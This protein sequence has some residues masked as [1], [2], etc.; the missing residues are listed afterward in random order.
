MGFL[1]RERAALE[2]LLPGLDAELA[3]LPLGALEAQGNPGVKLFREAGGAG[4]L[5]PAEHGGKGADALSAVRVQRAIGSRSPS[6]AV[7]TTMHHFSLA[8]LVVLSRTGN[9]FE[10]MLLTGIVDGRLLLA[11]GFA[12]GQPGG[13][14]LRPSMTAEV[15]EQGL[16]VSGAKRPCSLAR[17]MDLLTASV[18]VPRTDGTGEQLAVV[19]V[20]AGDPGLSVSPFWG[21]F[22]LAGAESDQVTVTD[23]LVPEDLVVRTDVP[24]GELLDDIQTTGFVWFELLMTASYLGAA[25]A[26]VERLLASPKVPVGDRMRLVT[27]LEAAMAGVEN[28]ARQT[29]AER[30]EPDLLVDSL[31]VRYAAQDAIARV[32]PRAVELLGGLN[33]MSSDDVAYLAAAVN[34]LG[35]HPPAR[36]RMAEPL[37]DHLAGRALAIV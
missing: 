17:S 2:A 15:T 27:E 22:A 34:G 29:G 23:V 8:S 36:G 33:F 25:S 7:A 12:E 3:A 6:L 32:V 5:I 4:L 14:I 19:L 26:L 1:D 35:L 37:A 18:M 30:C 24:E 9:G 13:S 20:P 10:W 31:H 16:R 11:S 21:S 28:V